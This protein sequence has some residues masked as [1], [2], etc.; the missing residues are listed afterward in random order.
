M[1]QRKRISRRSPSLCRRSNIEAL[2]GRLL[3]STY[4]VTT[5]GDSAGAVTPSGAGQF[6]ATTLRAAINASNAA[7]GADTIKFN[8][9]GTINLGS[10]LPNINDTLTITG[11]GASNLTVQRGTSVT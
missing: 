7:G 2:E 6:N 10:A 5:V 8:V 1:S 11:P 4:T 9:T 3:F